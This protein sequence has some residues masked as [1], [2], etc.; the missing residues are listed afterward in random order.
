MDKGS[1]VSWGKIVA[2]KRNIYQESEMNTIF[3]LVLQSRK[4]EV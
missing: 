4:D 1:E 2:I 3:W